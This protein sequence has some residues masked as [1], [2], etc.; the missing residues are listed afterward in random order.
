M[1]RL[2]REETWADA[3]DEL[4]TAIGAAAERGWCI[5]GIT[6]PG[7]AIGLSWEDSADAFLRAVR[8]AAEYATAYGVPLLLEPSLPLFAD[9]H[10]LHTL[11]DTIDVAAAAG[12]GVCFETNAS[13]A[14]RDLRRS[15]EAAG[16]TLG[17]VQVSD[18]VPAWRSTDRATP[19]DGVVPLERILA[20]ILET[21]YA[22]TFDLELWGDAYGDDLDAVRRGAD[23]IGALLDRLGVR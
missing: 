11:R 9:L 4:C 21:G 22:G 17:L 3:G 14:E 1:F 8:P 15:I 12:L 16:P 20:W 18:Y 23:H 19:G 5:Y 13:W 2:D 10:F 7:P 6:G